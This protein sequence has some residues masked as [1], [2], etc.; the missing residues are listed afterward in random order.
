MDTRTLAIDARI[1]AAFNTAVSVNHLWFSPCLTLCLYAF[2][3]RYNEIKHFSEYD[4]ENHQRTVQSTLSLS[5]P[6]PQ[7]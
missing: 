6:S 7:V 4:T 1:V 2:D 5:P 3:G